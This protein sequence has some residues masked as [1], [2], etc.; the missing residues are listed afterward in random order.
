M[1]LHLVDGEITEVGDRGHEHRVGAALDDS[2]V[3]VVELA[4]AAGGDD[5]DVDR[6][7]D[8]LV[9]LVVVAGPGA[10][11]VHT[12]Q[13]DLA[14]PQFLSAHGPF[15]HVDIRGLRTRFDADPPTRRTEGGGRRTVRVG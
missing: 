14:R 2:V 1:F 9:Q 7:G 15:H 4:R 8:G 5:G 11:G 10:V 3:E 12:G 6:V 13:Q